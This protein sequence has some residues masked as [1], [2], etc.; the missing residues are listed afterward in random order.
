VGNPWRAPGDTLLTEGN[1]R[2][3]LFSFFGRWAKPAAGFEVWGE[4]G[5]H[6]GPGSLGEL[7]TQL[8]HS[9]GYTV[10]TQVL[11][12]VGRV[13]PGARPALRW[14][15]QAEITELEPS[16]SYRVQ[17]FSEWYAS[18]A[19]PHGYTHMGRV[20]GAAI[21]PSGSSQWGATDLVGRWWSVGVYGTRIRWENQALYTFAS[22]FRRADLSIIG[23]LRGAFDTGLG[24]VAVEYA[25]T[26]RANYLFQS[27]PQPDGSE[28]GVDLLNQT[29]RVTVTV[30][31][32][33]E[34]R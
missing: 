33:G 28:R 21:G 23:G 22:E 10:G 4:W 31:G 30:G 13:R 2:D 32:R 3:Q 17:P 26:Q 14:R 18:R 16:I 8:H 19:V 5:R 11:R 9:R 1:R 25:N 27:Q 24:R 6:V 15:L 7:F 12:P 20:I 34:W 29:V